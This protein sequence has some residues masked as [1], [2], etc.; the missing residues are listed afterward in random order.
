MIHYYPGNVFEYHGELERILSQAA[1]ALVHS[2]HAA[3]ASIFATHTFVDDPEM[4]FMQVLLNYLKAFETWKIPDAAKLVT[5]IENGIVGLTLAEARIPAEE[6]EDSPLRVNFRR[7]IRTMKDK[8]AQIGGA[9]VLAELE[10]RLVV[11][12]TE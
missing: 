7:D 4:P 3:I 12:M 5:R 2:F 10:A 1:S 9:Q 8:L 11:L 6:P